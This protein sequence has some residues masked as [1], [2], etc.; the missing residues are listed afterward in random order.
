MVSRAAPLW[1]NILLMAN[2]LPHCRP[3][4]YRFLCQSGGVPAFYPSPKTP[5]KKD[6]IFYIKNC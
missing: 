6:N 4:L 5:E 1:G 3:E 2:S